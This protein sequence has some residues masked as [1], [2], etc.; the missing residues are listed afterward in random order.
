MKAEASIRELCQ[1]FEID[2]GSAVHLEHRDLSGLAVY[3]E[4]PALLNRLRRRK[5]NQEQYQHRQ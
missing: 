1:G 5:L 2:E 4:C 3:D